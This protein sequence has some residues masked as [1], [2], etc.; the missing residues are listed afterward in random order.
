MNNHFEQFCSQYDIH[1]TQRTAEELQK[2]ARICSEVISQDRRFVLEPLEVAFDH[3][4]DLIHSYS[5][6]FLPYIAEIPPDQPL[7][8]LKGYTPLH[9]AALH[10]YDHYLRNLTQVS[11]VDHVN[12]YDMTALHL[13]SIGAHLHSM[14]AL[15][16]LGAD[17]KR[18]NSRKQLPLHCVL[19]DPNRPNAPSATQQAQAFDWLFKLYPEGL[20]Q[21]D[22]AGQNVTHLM[23]VYGHND[24]LRK[25]IQLE[26]SLLS[27]K[28]AHSIAPIH[29]A[30]LNGQAETVKLILAEIP[31][32]AILTTQ[33]LRLPLHEAVLAQN[34]RM[35]G[36]CC[37]A[38]HT[39]S[40]LNAEDKD[41]RTPWM[42]ARDLN[43]VEIQKILETYRVNKEEHRRRSGHGFK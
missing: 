2:I 11:A 26:R 1:P 12:D 24:L 30:I 14:Q 4:L 20:R 6:Q 29:A 25:A 28:N 13:A 31:E 5:E 38:N 16:D 22:D 17:C 42:M 37:E 23:A 36:Y 18:K 27:N 8:S 35:V 33:R 10:G 32:A 40:V 21:V 15:C 9:Y 7:K 34:P 41:G 3:Y 43:N 19:T 39:D